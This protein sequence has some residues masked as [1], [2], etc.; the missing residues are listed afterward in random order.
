MGTTESAEAATIHRVTVMGFLR[1]HD[2]SGLLSGG[3]TKTRNFNKT[4]ELRH[5]SP[6]TSWLI[7]VCADGETLGELSIRLR[8]EG[9][10]VTSTVKLSLY[11]WVECDHTDLE[12]VATPARRRLGNGGEVRYILTAENGET[13]DDSAHANFSVTHNFGAPTE[14]TSVTATR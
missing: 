6:G 13:S 9:E 12:D 11:E 4:F 2:A 8:L 3:E 14:P 10:L 7:P 5:A 1:V